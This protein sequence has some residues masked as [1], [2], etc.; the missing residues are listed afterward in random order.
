[1]FD[2]SRRDTF[3]GARRWVYDLENKCANLKDGSS[4]PCLLL[5]N[6]CDLSE[7]QVYQEEIEEFCKE[8]DFIGWTETSVKEGQMVKESMKF[9][10]EA[11]MV[12]C[13][14]SD[15]TKSARSHSRIQLNNVTGKP[16]RSCHC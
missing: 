14:E 5:A 15:I 7:R 11:V 9:L 6:K 8:H 16:K 13:G 4:I 10:L 3:L 2:L 1:M 12:R